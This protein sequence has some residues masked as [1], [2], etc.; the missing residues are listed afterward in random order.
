MYKLN[1]GALQVRT[2]LQYVSFSANSWSAVPVKWAAQLLQSRR[3]SGLACRASF[4]RREMV[5]LPSTVVFSRQKLFAN[6]AFHRSSAITNETKHQGYQ[7]GSLQWFWHRNA[8]IFMIL[9]FQRVLFLTWGGENNVKRHFQNETG[10]IFVILKL[11]GGKYLLDVSF[12]SG[13]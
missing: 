7:H 5:Y 6:L 9:S 11:T 3:S 8:S 12:G 10:I 13:S 1:R 4:T 2:F